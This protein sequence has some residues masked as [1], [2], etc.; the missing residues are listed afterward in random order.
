MRTHTSADAQPDDVASV[1]S[2]AAAAA[3]PASTSPIIPKASDK[4][5]LSAQPAGAMDWR[6]S[7]YAVAALDALDP[8]VPTQITVM[9]QHVAVWRDDASGQW[10]ALRDEC[11]H[12]L[13]PLSEGR[14]AEDGT[15]QARAMRP[16]IV[17]NSS[18]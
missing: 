14:V 3:S 13:A 16:L 1:A 15:L 2:F 12:R 17:C 18:N 8:S 7:W 4:A 9:N 11:P 5:P 10:R 6:R